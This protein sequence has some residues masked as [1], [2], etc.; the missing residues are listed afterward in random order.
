[1]KLLDF[2]LVKLTIYLIVGIFIGAKIKFSVTQIILITTL[3]FALTSI[4]YFIS[5]N[6]FKKS[7]W[8]GT[9]AILSTISVGILTITLNNETNFRDHYLKKYDFNNPRGSHIILTINEQLKPSIFHNRYVGT[10]SQIDSV[11][12]EGK[13]QLNISKDS[14]SNLLPV[15]CQI[16]ATAKLKALKA[17]LNPNQFNYKSYLENKN[18]YAQV[19][20]NYEDLTVLKNHKLTVFGFANNIRQSIITNLEAYNFKPDELAVIKALLLGYRQDISKDLYEDYIDAGA[21]HILAISGLHIGIILIMLDFLLG[22]LERFKYGL[23]LKTVLIL[24]L[25]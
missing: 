19:N 1:M 14:I 22:F 4:S 6:T 24:I 25:L 23:L 7:I 20:C 12:V 8:F 16:V 2:P 13:V 11:I 9:C 15:D 5:K 17:P 10:V 18:I 3:L 21:I